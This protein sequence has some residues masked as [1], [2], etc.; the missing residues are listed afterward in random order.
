MSAAVKWKI[1]VLSLPQLCCSCDTVQV[2]VVCAVFVQYLSG[3]YYSY[4]LCVFYII[5]DLHEHTCRTLYFFSF[6]LD[7][8]LNWYC[9]IV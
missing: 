3:I 1:Q 4:I 5:V 9:S 8:A 6:G 2:Y 7:E